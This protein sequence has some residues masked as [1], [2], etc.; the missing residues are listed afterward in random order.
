M[1]ESIRTAYSSALGQVMRHLWADGLGLEGRSDVGDAVVG[2]CYR[3]TNQ[4]EEA[5]EAFFRLLES[6]WRLLKDHEESMSFW[7]HVDDSF[8][9]QVTE[10][11][12]KCNAGPHSY[13]QGRTCWECEG[14]RQPW[15]KWSWDGGIKFLRVRQKVR[16]YPRTSGETT[17][18]SSRICL[19]KIHQIRP[20]RE[21]EPQKLLCN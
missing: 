5:D 18:A 14:W 3:L 7:E 16:S 9:T 6:P 1:W 8:M 20:W 17:L 4:E 12:T 19:E 13:K 21:E 2:V 15:L 11:L 10:E